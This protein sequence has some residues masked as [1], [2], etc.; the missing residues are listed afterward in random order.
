[1]AI[2]LVSAIMQKL[3]ERRKMLVERVLKQIEKG[4]GSLARIVE[5]KREI[6][7]EIDLLKKEMKKQGIQFIFFEG[8]GLRLLVY[9]DDI[10]FIDMEK[11]EILIKDLDDFLSMT[12]EV[13]E[14]LYDFM[15]KIE[16]SSEVSVDD[17]EITIAIN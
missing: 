5:K 11:E 14:L 4:K 13:I 6:F 12:N 2:K 15:K 7:E 16:A 1:M 9:K 3:V 17:N 8:Y 10:V